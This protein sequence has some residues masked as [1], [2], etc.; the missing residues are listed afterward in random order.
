MITAHEK[1]AQSLEILKQLQ[2]RHV[3]AIQSRDLSRTHRDRLVKHGFLQEVIK[4]WYIATSPGELPGD[5]TAWY[6]SFW[7]FIASY[8]QQKFKNNWCL[9]P[10]QSI[11]LH[12]GNWTIPKQLLIR[13]T[14]GNN[15]VIQLP[16]HT[17]ILDV[18]YRM[19]EQENIVLINQLR[20]FSLPS[21]LIA[22]APRFFIQNPID[23]KTTLLLIRDSAELLRGL[24]KGGHTSIAGRL[25]GAFR[26]IG[27][28]RI[29]DDILTTMR[30]MDY[31]AREENPFEF[32]SIIIQSTREKSPYVIRLQTAWQMMRE[33]VIQYFPK[34]TFPKI[35]PAAYLKKVEATYITD[36]YHS[37]SIEGYVVSQELL[38]R[39]RSGR[40]NPNL[41]D[42]DKEHRSAMAARG[43]W[44]AFQEV[45]KSLKKVLMGDNPGKVF[46]RDHTTWFQSLFSPSA[47]AGIIKPDGLLG[48]RNHPVYIRRSQHVPPNAEAVRDLMP[49]FCDL[50]IEENEPSVRI[51]LGHFFFVY[52]H[53]YMDGNGRMGRFLMNL[54]M[55][56]AQ[57]PWT[58]IPVEQRARYMH[59][60]EMASTQQNIKPF[61]Q[62]IGELLLLVK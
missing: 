18:R 37:L 48:Y 43:Y 23:I 24:L 39:V 21:A 47:V 12:A 14:R 49:A 27:R 44:Q 31:L 58:V 51:V 46:D 1:L 55:A 53:P 17:S 6:L 3:K 15:K 5:S 8:L 38:E 42:T 50:L 9:S 29:A 41:Y 34:H 36:A 19:P 32:N 54:M 61:T 13:S 25:A 16:H 10:E 59:A 35:S 62:F 33:T 11:A 57:Y 26:A 4:G 30:R 40:W 2:D 22:C 7:D 52:I 20:V 28:D 45:E 60:L 56:A